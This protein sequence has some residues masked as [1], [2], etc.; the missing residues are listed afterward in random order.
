MSMWDKDEKDDKVREFPS[1]RRLELMD[2]RLRSIDREMQIQSKQL[3]IVTVFVG[4]I[5][6]AIWKGGLPA[7]E[8]GK[9]A[10]VVSD[11]G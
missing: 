4:I 9:V 3:I 7:L 2:N 11:V 5:T 1:D 6:Y 10:E 8:P